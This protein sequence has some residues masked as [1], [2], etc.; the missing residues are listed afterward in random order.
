MYYDKISANIR[1]IR[2]ELGKT[3]VEMA[4]LLNCSESAYCKFEEGKTNIVSPHL[5]AMSKISGYSVVEI[6]AGGRIIGGEHGI[7]TVSDNLDEKVE[8]KIKDLKERN[9]VLERRIE[10]LLDHFASINAQK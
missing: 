5:V 8:Q 1:K 2:E 9:A 7:L 10:A 6:L 4:E 3:Q